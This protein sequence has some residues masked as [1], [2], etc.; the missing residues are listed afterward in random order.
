[1][2]D[3]LD[4]RFKELNPF[5][6]LFITEEKK[7]FDNCS[8][9][10]RKFD[11]ISQ[12]MQTL[13]RNFVST[14]ITYDPTRYIRATRILDVPQNNERRGS[15]SG[16]FPNSGTV[17]GQP[18]DQSSFSYEDYKKRQGGNPPPGPGG[19][20]GNS[21]NYGG[22]S[23]Y[24]RSNT[25]NYGNT[26]NEP[27]TEEANPYSYEAYKKKMN[28]MN[29]NKSG[30]G[31]NDFSFADNNQGSNSQIQRSQTYSQG[32][33]N[34]PGNSGQ[35]QND[36][37]FGNSGNNFGQSS[38]YGQGGSNYGSGGSNNFGQGG[39]NYDQGANNFNFDTGNDFVQPDNPY[40]QIDFGPS[41]ANNTFQN[42]QSRGFQN[43]DFP[44]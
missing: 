26:S 38:N 32:S 8:N 37:S 41:N 28:D 30:Q 6:C 16:Y 24:G 36:Y 2:Q 27:K 35:P 17:G 10:L 4:Y 18:Q 12:K 1:M 34:F 33:S 21:G 22:N 19:N 39:S 5:I 31:N 42:N 7:L 3:L 25:Y 20:Y 11:G 44:K 14:K 43:N 15:N 9:F 23:D 29:K 40:A 13:E